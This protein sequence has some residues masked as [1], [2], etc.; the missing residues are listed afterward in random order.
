MREAKVATNEGELILAAAYT[1]TISIRFSSS[2][3]VSHHSSLEQV[4]SSSIISILSPTT[5][6]IA[7][8]ATDRT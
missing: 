4:S 8:K 3:L 1:A 2:V 7:T 6:P 5:I